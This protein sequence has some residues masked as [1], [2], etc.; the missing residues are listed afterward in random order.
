MLNLDE[1]FAKLFPPAEPEMG[2]PIYDLTDDEVELIEQI[3]LEKKAVDLTYRAAIEAYQEAM[4]IYAR[5][6]STLWK[7]LR[8]KVGEKKWPP[9]GAAV[10]D[11]ATRKL[12]R[13]DLA[14]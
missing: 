9:S 7:H 6:N 5:N 11:T 8:A 4:R 10:A 2:E 12:Y 14:R 3:E 1:A 13:K